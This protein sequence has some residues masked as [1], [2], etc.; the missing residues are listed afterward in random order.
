M[1]AEHPPIVIALSCVACLVYGASGCVFTYWIA[2]CCCHPLYTTFPTS[3]PKFFL[4]FFN[5]HKRSVESSHIIIV[6]LNVFIAV[7]SQNQTVLRSATNDEI[8]MNTIKLEKLVIGSV[9]TAVPCALLLSAYISVI[10]V[11]KLNGAALNLTIKKLASLVL[12][13]P[14]AVPVRSGTGVEDV[15]HNQVNKVSL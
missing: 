15:P 9:I 2:T 13:P 4:N 8:M 1:D 7:F 12:S 6:L 14:S 5:V 11:T 3:T 10:I